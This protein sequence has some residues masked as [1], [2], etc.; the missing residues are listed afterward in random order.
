MRKVLML[1]G[2]ALVAACDEPKQRDHTPSAAPPP[3]AAPAAAWTAGLEGQVVATAFPGAFDCKAYVDGP[4]D[5][6]AERVTIVGWAWIPGKAAGASRIVV[7][8]AT[9]KIV[10]FGE[11]GIPR[12]DVQAAMKD[13]TSPDV[14]FQASAPLTSGSVTLF[15]VDPEAKAACKLGEAR[16]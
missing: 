13:V 1:A 16:L 8:D 5:R 4:T 15:G 2:L 6:T 10:G 12:P 3:A 9:G 7:A 14:G 11:G